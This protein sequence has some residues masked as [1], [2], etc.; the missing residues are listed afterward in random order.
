MLEYFSFYLIFGQAGIYDN[1]PVLVFPSQCQVA[2][3]H[4]F[5]K[6]YRLPLKSVLT[7]LGFRLIPLQGPTK[8]HIDGTI[9]KIRDN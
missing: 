1:K 5:M 8:A 6:I 4:G 7:F 3:P 9:Q 2:F